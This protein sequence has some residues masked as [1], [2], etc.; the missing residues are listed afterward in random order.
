M[1]G[2]AAAFSGADLL[3]LLLLVPE[4]QISMPSKWAT[5]IEHKFLNPQQP[6]LAHDKVRDVGEAIAIVV[7]E[8]RDQA[9]DAAEKVT[10]DLEE[11]PAVVHPQAAL[12][13]ESAIVDDQS[14][15]RLLGRARRRRGG[16]GACATPPQAALLSS[17]LRRRADGMPRRGC[18]R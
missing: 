2:V 3:R 16:A 9:E 17:S 13:A 5:V 15:R 6:L 11:L 4:G 1:P 14:D 10:F 12:R 18:R 7:A 8:S